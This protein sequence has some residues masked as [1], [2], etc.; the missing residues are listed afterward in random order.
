MADRSVLFL[1]MTLLAFFC[2]FVNENGVNAASVPE[3]LEKRSL[4]VKQLQTRDIWSPK[5]VDP[6][7]GTVWH[8][9]ELANITWY[10]RLYVF[11]PRLVTFL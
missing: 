10:V 5:I 4:G 8:V 2:L 1:L 11:F 9:G 6:K 3:V 7:V